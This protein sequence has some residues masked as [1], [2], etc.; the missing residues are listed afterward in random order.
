MTP[1]YTISTIDY[2][3]PV[4]PYVYRDWFYIDYKS[5]RLQLDRLYQM[6][7]FR[8]YLKNEYI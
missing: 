5:Y 3:G 4:R 6:P 1:L 7:T 2:D 8:Y